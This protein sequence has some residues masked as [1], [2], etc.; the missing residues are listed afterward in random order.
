MSVQSPADLILVHP[1]KNLL[2]ECKEEQGTSASFSR[3]K[4]HQEDALLDFRRRGKIGTSTPRNQSF[5]IVQFTRVKDIRYL[6]IAIP[7]HTWRKERRSC[8]RKSINWKRAMELGISLE[9]V[10]GSKW[11]IKPL[12]K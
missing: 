2:L 11:N 12:L 3:L 5:V 6:C 8:G 10:K 9:R 4:E 1:K 7:V